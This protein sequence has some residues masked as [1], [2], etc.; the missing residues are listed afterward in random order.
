MVKR[1][2]IPDVHLPNHDS[3]AWRIMLLAAK[4]FKP[5]EV[6]IL[7][8]FFDCYSVSRYDKHPSKMY[9]DLEEELHTGITAVERLLNL[10]KPKKL[11][12]LEGNHEKRVSDY[13]KNNAP[14]LVGTMK[15]PKE[16]FGL[17][18]KCIYVPYGIGG[19]INFDGLYA[20][21]GFVTGKNT[22]AKSLDRYG[23]SVIYGHT[24]QLG[25]AHKQILDGPTIRAFNCGWLG[26]MEKAA[27]DYVKDIASWTHGF[28]TGIFPKSGKWTIN[29]HTIIDYEVTVSGK[30]YGSSVQGKSR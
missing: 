21:H 9:L 29:L 13:L 25:E 23:R 12:F 6:V 28:A 2:F 26:D 11:Y 8:D 30:T 18:P 7:G 1:L 27:D 22:P 20:M 10:L 3:A 14:L 17:P 15:E 24:H 5:D 4:D 19:Y 16:L